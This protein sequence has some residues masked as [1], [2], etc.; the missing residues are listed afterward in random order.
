MAPPDKRRPGF[1]RKAQYKIFTGYLV[2]FLGAFGGLFLLA[3]SYLDPAAFSAIRHGAADL[4][5][6]VTEFF[7]AARSTGQKGSSEVSAYFDAAS[8]N[9]AMQRELEQSRTQLIEARALKQENERLR[10]LLGLVEEE[11]E[12]VAIARLISSTSSSTRRFAT[13]GAGRSQ[14]V[15]AGQPVREQRG[16]IGRVLSTGINTS[17]VLLLTD[18][19]NVVPVKRASD[20]TVAFAEGRG[21]GLL[22]IRL[23]NIGANDVKPGDIFVTSGNGGLYSPNIPVA[24]VDSLANDGAVGRPLSDPAAADFVVVQPIYQPELVPEAQGG[25]AGDEASGDDTEGGQ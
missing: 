2:A 21:D 7:T 1:S 6:P 17:R 22:N 9:A 20:G 5:R 14:G 3:I 16:L 4:T 15:E 11:G 18:T 23:I 12:P 24:I 10:S 25:E 8:K 13:L 19:N